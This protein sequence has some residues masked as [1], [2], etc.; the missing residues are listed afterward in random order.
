VTHCGWNSAVEALAAGVPV[1]TY[2]SW[3]SD[4]LTNGKFLTDVFG[5]G[6]RLSKPM[7]REVLCRC[8]EEVMS[9]PEAAATRER[10]GTWKDEANASLADGGS[11]EKGVLG[12]VDAV[13][14]IGAGDDDHL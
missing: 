12:F 9:G 13:L 10:A 7:A 8:V 2:P 11:S 5:V 14:S 6:V 1:V 3:M 4:Q